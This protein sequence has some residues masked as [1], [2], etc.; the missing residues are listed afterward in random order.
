MRSVSMMLFGAIPAI[1]SVITL[2][3]KSELEKNNAIKS[4]LEKNKKYE[5]LATTLY[6]TLDHKFIFSIELENGLFKCYIERVPSFRGRDTSNYDYHYYTNQSNKR[7]YICYT[8]K[9]EYLE[10]GRTL[11]RKWA[12]AHQRFIDTGKADKEFIRRR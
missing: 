8:G 3:I 6:P 10:Q 12:D 2:A 11:C 1:V 5:Y 4:E 7:K 9:I